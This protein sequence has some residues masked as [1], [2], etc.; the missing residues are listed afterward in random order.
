MS[1]SMLSSQKSASSSK[2][3]SSLVC[4]SRFPSCHLRR[5]RKRARPHLRFHPKKSSVTW[6][7]LP[8][9]SRPLIWSPAPSFQALSSAKRSWK[10]WTSKRDCGGS[11]TFSS[12]KFAPSGKVT[13][14]ER[15]QNFFRSRTNPRRD[16][17]GPIRPSRYATI[18]HGHDA[19][20]E[21]CSSRDRQA[22]ARPRIRKTFHRP[23]GDARSQDQRQPDQRRTKSP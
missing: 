18:E 17:V 23:F 7:P 3:E 15:A 8:I 16:D 13:R 21:S 11:S 2:S 5:A 6:I 1:K 12:P 14:H 22:R 10:P 9:R 4:L 20:G 19:D